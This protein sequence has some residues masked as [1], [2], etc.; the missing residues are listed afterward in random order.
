LCDYPLHNKNVY[1]FNL[2]TSFRIEAL[3]G[4]EISTGSSFGIVLSSCQFAFG[5]ALF[6]PF[7]NPSFVYSRFSFP[8]TALS[9]E[10][11]IRLASTDICSTA[12]LI[13]SLFSCTLLSNHLCFLITL[14]PYL[15]LYSSGWS[16]SVPL[17]SSLIFDLSLHCCLNCW[18]LILDDCLLSFLDLPHLHCCLWISSVHQPYH[19]VLW[20]LYFPMDQHLNLCYVRCYCSGCSIAFV[21]WYHCPDP[22]CC[23]VSLSLFGLC[24]AIQTLAWIFPIWLI[25]KVIKFDVKLRWH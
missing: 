11:G 2:D 21:S 25:Q 3:G 8:R 19:F 12:F 23:L 10:T 14:L 1:L 6:A 18:H 16:I 22:E 4:Q 5:E 7:L 24:I 20:N 9:L 17:F 15:F 13:S